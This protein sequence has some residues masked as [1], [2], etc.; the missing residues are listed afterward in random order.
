MCHLLQLAINDAF[1]VVKYFYTLVKKI[2]HFISKFRVS[3]IIK[4]ELIE[5]KKTLL[6]NVVTRWHSIYFMVRSFNKVSVAEQKKLFSKIKESEQ[7]ACTFTFVERERA[8]ELEHVL[9]VLL[10]AYT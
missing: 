10:F 6:K 2:S 1:K 5:M 9:D 7:K 4:N 3:T 8:V